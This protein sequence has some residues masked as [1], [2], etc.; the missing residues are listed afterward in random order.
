MALRWLSWLLIE[1]RDDPGL[2]S[3][4]GYVQLMLG[5]ITA[6]DR[7]FHKA[8][9]LLGSARSPDQQRQA[10]AI[11]RRHQGL[12]LF[13]RNDFAGEVVTACDM[14]SCL[15]VF[16]LHLGLSSHVVCIVDTSA[17]TH[18]KRCD[19]LMLKHFVCAVLYCLQHTGLSL[20]HADSCNDML[21]SLAVGYG[22]CPCYP[23][24]KHCSL[25]G[26]IC[27]DCE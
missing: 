1:R 24:S 15:L 17:C 13:A 12:L 6:A 22:Q 3:V 18:C 8:A 2:W 14:T 19:S 21:R 9:E 20:L 10:Q 5:D 26:P 25:A 11:I 7:T 27:W 16:S 23:C 4:V